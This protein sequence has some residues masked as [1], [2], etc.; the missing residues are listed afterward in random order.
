M[1][2]ILVAED[3]A[4]LAWVI[5]QEL[6]D[7]GFDVAVA[8]NGVEAL[9]VV[10]K[11]PVDL[12][13]TD[14]MMPEMNGFALFDALRKSQ[15]H[16]PIVAMTGYAGANGKDDLARLRSA[17]VPVLAKPFAPGRII[18]TVRAMLDTSRPN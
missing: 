3:E 7:A 5:E 8:R 18:D 6:R 13:L 16:L 1:P 10:Q 9:A 11:I 4:L 12:V 14:I 17:G 2:S 15:P